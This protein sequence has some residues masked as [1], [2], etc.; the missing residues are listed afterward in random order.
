MKGRILYIGNQLSGENS[1]PSLIDRL[2]PRLRNRGFELILA[3]G[4]PRPWARALDMARTMAENMAKVDRVLIDTYS[5]LAFHYAWICGEWARAQGK[6]YYPILHG[7]DLESRMVR[8]P[9]ICRRFFGRS[10]KNIL[11]SDFL[12][13][14]MDSRGFAYEIIP[15]G[16]DLE[17]FPFQ[18]RRHAGPRL[19]WVRAFSSIYQPLMAVDLVRRLKPRL[20]DIMLRMV[21]PDKDGSLAHC[22]EKVREW[23][24]EHQV[25]FLG[26]MSQAEWA[27]LSRDSDIFI[28]T[29]RV[30]NMPVSLL[31]SLALGLPMI[32]LKT[33]GI[34]RMIRH[35]KEGWLVASLE[36]MARSVLFLMEN[37]AIV[38]SLSQ[39]GRMKAESFGW[40]AIEEK[41][42]ALWERE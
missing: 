33:G 21:G 38:S 28:N 15:N 20:P 12:A 2:S 26:P 35:G 6:P 27:E 17:Y 7:G 5:T 39:A 13:P 16:I 30:D 24:L 32:S 10:R 22:R 23:G 40:T 41:W 34:P 9:R 37:P 29:S 36:D 31:E 4:D 19:L 18:L 25:E 42:I 11:V 8:S 1:S 3:S 14:A